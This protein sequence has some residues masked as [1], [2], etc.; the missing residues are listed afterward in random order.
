M[1][2]YPLNSPQA[3]ARIVAL[4]LLAD[5]H[6]N[7]RELDALDRVAAHEQL[8]LTRPELHSVVQTLC[9][10]LLVAAQFCWDNACRLD[11]AAIAG[12]MAEVDDPQLW[13]KVMQI[14]EAVIDADGHVSDGELTV[15]RAAAE[16]AQRKARAAGTPQPLP[17]A[18]PA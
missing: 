7:R 10:D 15:L 6:V 1:R 12:L 13:R 9:E 5:G 8:G 11:A 4:A 3:A 18:Q 14:C 16:S 2:N 17:Q